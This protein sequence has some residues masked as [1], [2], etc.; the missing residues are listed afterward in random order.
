MGPRDRQ[1][2]PQKELDLNDH[3]QVQL[4]WWKHQNLYNTFIMGILFKGQTYIQNPIFKPTSL[5]R[6]GPRERPVVHQKEL[7]LHDR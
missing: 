7:S 5:V 1:V 3:Q 2:D 6:M 4:T